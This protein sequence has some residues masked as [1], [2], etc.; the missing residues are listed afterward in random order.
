MTNTAFS[1]TLLAPDGFGRGQ[2][3]GLAINGTQITLSYYV[4]GPEVIRIIDMDVTGQPGIGG[5]AMGS[6]FGRGCASCF[7]N[8]SLGPSVMSLGQILTD[9]LCPTP[10]SVCLLRTQTAA[11]SVGLAMQTTVARPVPRRSGELL[12]WE[13]RI[14]RAA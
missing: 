6:A 1:G 12:H 5:A 13:H 10:R 7:S 14:W 4:V 2:T 11:H 3:S 8:E 9:W